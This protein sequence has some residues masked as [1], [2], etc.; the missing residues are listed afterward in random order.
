MY[1][2]SSKHGKNPHACN[3]SLVRSNSIKSRNV[4]W[5][6]HD[7]RKWGATFLTR[8]KFLMNLTFLSIEIT[9]LWN[10]SIS[11]LRYHLIVLRQTFYLTWFSLKMYFSWYQVSSYLNLCLSLIKLWVKSW[12]LYS[13]TVKTLPWNCNSDDMSA[14]EMTVSQPSS[15]L[16]APLPPQEWQGGTHL[17][18]TQMLD[19]PDPYDPFSDQECI[20][21]YT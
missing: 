12:Y 6:L 5:F 18:L 10:I 16:F 11:N 20:A 14:L 4:W 8:G 2:E 7:C 3:F 13:Q 17:P 1:D 19:A 15:H 9:L 21:F